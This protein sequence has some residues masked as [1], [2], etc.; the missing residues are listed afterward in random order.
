M[1]KLYNPKLDNMSFDKYSQMKLTRQICDMMGYTTDK[2]CVR[3]TIHPFTS[4]FN[5]NDVRITTAYDE[6]LL[7]SNIYSVMHET[8]HALYELGCDSKLNGTSLFG[9]TSMGIHESQSRFMENYLG[10]SYSFTKKLYKM[11]KE[12]Y[13]REF[14][15]ITVDDLY[16]Y[17]NNV[18]NQFKRTEADELTYPI[19][20]LIRYEVEK[21]LFNK[22]ITTEQIS[23]KFNDLFEEYLGVRPSNKLEGCFQDVHWSSD[24]GYFPTYAIG[25][26]L[27]A[28][29]YNYML[30]DTE[31]LDIKGDLA[32][33]DFSKI[34]K[35]MKDWVFTDAEPDLRDT[36]DWIK[37]I[38]DE[39]FNPHYFIDYLKDKY[40]DI[41]N[42]R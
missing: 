39:D 7:L 6:K 34:N 31:E 41:Y 4:G 35:W 9:G 22:E 25:N 8:G 24:F 2:G 1:P 19:H 32:K 12:L 29:Y 10:R 36:L 13:P 30:E 40:S 33:C 37:Y 27:N 21:A 20:I 17:A 38:T 11:I 14:S 3:E 26:M 28:M 15:D 5:S 23:D 18:S 42:I 16:Y